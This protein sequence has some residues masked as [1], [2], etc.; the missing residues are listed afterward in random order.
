MLLIAVYTTNATDCL[1]V[2]F[3]MLVLSIVYLAVMVTSS[4]RIAA[5]FPTFEFIT[6]A[7]IVDSSVNV[8]SAVYNCQLLLTVVGSFRYL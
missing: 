8:N 1:P 6:N 7:V 3:D 2:A 5:P 4:T